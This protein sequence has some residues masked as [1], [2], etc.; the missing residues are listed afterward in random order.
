MRSLDFSLLPMP[1]RVG[2]TLLAAA[3]GSGDSPGPEGAVRRDSSGIEIVE[4]LRPLWDD[5]AHW[6]AGETPLLVLGEESAG[7]PPL[8]SVAG[9]AL[10]QDGGMVVVD[11][12]NSRIHFFREDGT[13]A[14]T[15]GRPG[16]GPGEYRVIEG[17]DVVGDSA[18]VVWDFGLARLTYLSLEGELRATAPLDPVVPALGLVGV[19]PTEEVVLAQFWSPQEMQSLDQPG[20]MRTTA[21]VLR[22]APG[23]QVLDTVAIVSGREFMLTPEDG[24]MVM[25]TPPFGRAGSRALRSDELIEGD[26]ETFSLSVISMDGTV[27]A[28]YRLPGVD[29]TLTAAEVEAWKES[30]IAL[31]PPGREANVRGFLEEAEIPPTRPAYDALLVDPRGWIW[32]EDYSWDDSEAT[33]WTVLDGVGRWLGRIPMPQGFRPV[34]I[35]EDRAVGIHTD[36]MGVQRVWVLA[37]GERPPPA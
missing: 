28:V 3:C 8:E 34:E 36:P 16:D 22:V 37:L 5:A 19:L 9:V 35:L 10:L 17:L 1:L 21:A 20:L 12:G 29:L 25:G 26:Q 14:R 31:A 11:G 7:H 15:V 33:T 2:V 6:H 30:Q 18:L 27:R 24:R 13:L 32:A 4:N 23:G